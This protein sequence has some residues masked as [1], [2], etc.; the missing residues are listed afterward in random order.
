[1]SLPHQARVCVEDEVQSVQ[2]IFLAVCRWQGI[3]M[4]WGVLLGTGSVRAAISTSAGKG[5]SLRCAVDV[6]HKELTGMNPPVCPEKR[7]KACR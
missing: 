1:V 5:A 6:R 7:Q 3:L 4:V 2:R